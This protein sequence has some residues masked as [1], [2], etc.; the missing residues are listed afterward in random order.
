MKTNIAAFTWGR[1]SQNASSEWNESKSKISHNL[2]RAEIMY[3]K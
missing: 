2:G 3:V 1:R